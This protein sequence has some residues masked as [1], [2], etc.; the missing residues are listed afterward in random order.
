MCSWGVRGVLLPPQMC[1]WGGKR[2]VP[3][4]ADVQLGGQR[5]VP[6][7]PDV[8]LWGERGVPATPDVQLGHERGAAP[9]LGAWE[10]GWLS[11]AKAELQPGFG[12]TTCC[13]NRGPKRKFN[14][15]LFFFP[16]P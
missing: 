12:N 11:L 8:Q 2:G 5:G 14:V 3:A 7:T 16:F 6:A 10:A 13:R 9:G 15:F 4:T 1:S